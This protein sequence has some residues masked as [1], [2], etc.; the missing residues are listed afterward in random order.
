MATLTT[1]Q[2]RRETDHDKLV[3]ECMAE[4]SLVAK[5][6]AIVGRNEMAENSLSACFGLAALFRREK[7]RAKN[8]NHRHCDDV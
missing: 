2:H 7:A 3:V 5:G 6:E 1:K 4:P 8:W